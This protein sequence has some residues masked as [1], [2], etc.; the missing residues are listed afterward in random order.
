M[1][2]RKNRSAAA[3]IVAKKTASS[4]TPPDHAPLKSTT[5]HSGLRKSK[6]TRPYPVPKFKSAA[7]K[8]VESI[9]QTRTSK[10][11]IIDL[12]VQDPHGNRIESGF[13]SDDTQWLRLV[14]VSREFSDKVFDLSPLLVLPNLA[15]PLAEGIKNYIG[16]IEPK[17]CGAAIQKFKV[18]FVVYL[19]RHKPDGHLRDLDQQTLTDYVRWQSSPEASVIGGDS[20]SSET[21]RGRINVVR[22]VLRGLSTDPRWNSEAER[23]LEI[24]PQRTHRK[25]NPWSDAAEKHLPIVTLQAILRASLSEMQNI[26]KRLTFIERNIRRL[27]KAI[28]ENEKSAKDTFLT[29]RVADGQVWPWLAL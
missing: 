22:A 4:S 8:A 12:P 14:M 27:Q 20:L 9:E 29:M 24:F 15:V 18:G 2:K 16:T 21:A 26:E 28:K 7:Q 5:M 1:P 11:V 10:K 6:F 25:S 23:V 19:V 17:A 13:S 3:L